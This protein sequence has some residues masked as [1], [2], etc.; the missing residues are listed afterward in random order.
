MPFQINPEILLRQK[1]IKDFIDEEEDR[2]FER[3]YK[4]A[5]LDRQR[6]EQEDFNLTRTAEQAL[7]KAQLGQQ[8]TPE[9]MAAARIY[10]AKRGGLQYDPATGG[11]MQKPSILGQLGIEGGA[12]QGRATMGSVMSQPEAA[13]YSQPSASTMGDVFSGGGPRTAPPDLPNV[14]EGAAQGQEMPDYAGYDMAS[15]QARQFPK[16]L[17]EGAG[18]LAKKTPEWL[19][20]QQDIFMKAKQSESIA[21][22]ALDINKG[23][24]GGHF[25]GKI[26]EFVGE[27][28]PS[29]LG[30]EPSK[31]SQAESEFQSYVNQLVVPEVKMLGA[32]PT[33]ADAARIESAKAAGSEPRQ[34]RERVLN[35]AIAASKRLQAITKLN[36][37]YLSRGQSI[38]AEIV[39]LIYSKPEFQNNPEGFAE[40]FQ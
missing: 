7:M 32:N 12:P 27:N 4:T 13:D 24:T 23:A 22:K 5:Q 17:A 21:R 14:F 37:K 35:E 34:V 30:K 16:T 39:E 9:E 26:E 3:Q 19:K 8:L 15:Q 25:A 1:T 36:M 31:R 38:P 33:N 40:R 11:F 29:I 18:E 2:Q 10:D 6:A 20:E 28:I